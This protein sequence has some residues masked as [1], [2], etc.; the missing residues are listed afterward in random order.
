M[1]H[2][3]T[4]SQK[5]KKSVLDISFP[6][7]HK[8][9]CCFYHTVSTVAMLCNEPQ[10]NILHP[11]Q[12]S[13]FVECLCML[14]LVA[15]LCI[16]LSMLK[17]VLL[18]QWTISD[19]TLHLFTLHCQLGPI[20]SCLLFSPLL[21]L[22]SPHCWVCSHQIPLKYIFFLSLYTF[23]IQKKHMKRLG[24]TTI[25]YVALSCLRAEKEA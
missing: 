10:K 20:Q 22:L 25:I 14:P 1:L 9:L 6:V 11:C 3:E 15:F 17:L 5:K 12:L 19:V 2:S 23:Q 8:S 13:G 16:H 21:T 18:A 7:L 4:F 24:L